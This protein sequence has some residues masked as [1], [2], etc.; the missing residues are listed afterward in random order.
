[1][2]KRWDPQE[3]E[4]IIHKLQLSAWGFCEDE[5][6]GPSNLKE[7]VNF[8]KYIRGGEFSFLIN[9]QQWVLSILFFF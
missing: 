4:V 8:I 3:S 2:L 5:A 1:M 6:F 9:L 7:N